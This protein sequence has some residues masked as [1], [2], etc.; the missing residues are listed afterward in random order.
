MAGSSP[1]FKAP[2]QIILLLMLFVL[3][4]VLY[5]II[6]QKPYKPR[7]LVNLLLSIFISASFIGIVSY[8]IMVSVYTSLLNESFSLIAGLAYYIVFLFVLTKFL[9]SEF[10]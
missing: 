3:T 10:F 8:Q 5:Y 6:L 1:A 9:Y 2:S 4:S 7:K